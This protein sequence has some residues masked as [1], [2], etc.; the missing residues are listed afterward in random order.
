MEQLR[1]VGYEGEIREEELSQEGMTVQQDFE[2]IM[3]G[4]E[5]DE[6][7]RVVSKS[8]K[9]RKLSWDENS[10]PMFTK[11]ARRI[12][13]H[14]SDGSHWQLQTNDDGSEFIVA[15]EDVPQQTVESSDAKIEEQEGPWSVMS[16]EDGE[17]LI[18]SYKDTEVK[19]FNMKQWKFDDHPTI[20]AQA[21]LNT[22]KDPQSLYSM[23][24]DELD[25]VKAAS[26]LKVYEGPRTLTSV[27]QRKA[28]E[29]EVQRK[30]IR[31]WLAKIA[32]TMKAQGATEVTEET[33][34]ETLKGTAAEVG[35]IEVA[36]DFIDDLREEFRALQASLKKTA[37]PEEEPAPAPESVGT[38]PEETVEPEV[39]GAE[40]PSESEVRQALERL[41]D[42][43]D[44]QQAINAKMAEVQK[45]LQEKYKLSEK[46]SEKI[47]A[48]EILK[49]E[50][51]ERKSQQARIRN[52]IFRLNEYTPKGSFS[53][54]KFRTAAAQK[55]EVLEKDVKALMDKS[56]T[57]PAAQTQLQVE[58]VQGSFID[59][60]KNWVNAAWNWFRGIGTAQDKVEQDLEELVELYETEEGGTE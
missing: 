55:W 40:R 5:E 26:L 56:K 4:Q 12:Y 42:V 60:V 16:S 36:I 18:L 17:D 54:P 30:R 15:L 11:L 45:D 31:G 51:P 49:R 20:A 8:S 41:A 10:K 46:M 44:A 48:E 21:I 35:N 3:R 37:A 58:Q 27:L 38:P 34:R 43:H 24:K 23:F 50:I 28:D 33:I 13:R 6:F 53:A 9:G 32:G 14:A 59:T 29:R 22:C 1:R 52:L 39:P 47:A 57:E 25:Q 2:T 7:K 19:A